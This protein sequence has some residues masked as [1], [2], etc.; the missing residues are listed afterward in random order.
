[1]SVLTLRG[2]YITL[3]H[4]IKAAGLVETGGQAKHVVRAGQ[5][6]VN[7]E[8]ENRPG[9]KLVAGDRFQVEGQPEWTVSA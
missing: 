1:M 6:S 9:R 2:P 3:G 8:V 5:A 4:A 7:G